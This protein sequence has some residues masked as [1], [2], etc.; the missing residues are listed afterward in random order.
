MAAKVLLA[1]LGVGFVED[2]DAA[3]IVAPE[4][5]DRFDNGGL[6][7]GLPIVER[8]DAGG[9]GGRVLPLH[10]HERDGGLHIRNSSALFSQPSSLIFWDAVASLMRSMK[11]NL[12]ATMLLFK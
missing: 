9:G 1:F 10:K 5:A 6:V 7:V 3:V 12:N 4:P 11:A 8:V 2:T